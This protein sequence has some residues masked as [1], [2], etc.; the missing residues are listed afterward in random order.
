EGYRQ[1]FVGQSAEQTNL[2]VDE[3]W[4][5]GPYAPTNLD[6]AG[7]LSRVK[8]L[9]LEDFA[10]EYERLLSNI[11]LAAFATPEEAQTV[12]GIMSD[13]ATS[14]LILLVRSVAEEMQ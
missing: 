11:A 3:S 13:P 1:F 10:R 9:Y 8:N 4:I 5:L 12:L 2:L 6:V 14:P 7:V